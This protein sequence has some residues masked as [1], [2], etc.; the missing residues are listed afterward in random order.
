MK[1]TLRS[2]LGI[3]LF[4]SVLIT[5]C[6]TDQN[7]NETPST[8]KEIDKNHFV[9][10][11]KARIIA[12]KLNLQD[13]YHH[14][15]SPKDE[16]NHSI[17][18]ETVVEGEDLPTY[19]VFNYADVDGFAIISADLRC[20]PILAYSSG[21]A[22]PEIGTEIPAGLAIQLEEYIQH[23][24]ELRDAQTKL[25]D[26]IV[27]LWKDATPHVEISFDGLEIE[28]PTVEYINYKSE[29]TQTTSTWGPLVQ[30]Q[31]GQGCGYNNSAPLK[32]CS[33]C[34]SRALVGCVATATGQIMRYWQ[35]PSSYSWSSMPTGNNPNNTIAA[36][37][38]D[39]GDEVSMNYGC[40]ASSAKTNDARKALENEFG[41]STDADYKD[42]SQSTVKS[43][44]Q[45]NRPVILRGCRTREKK[46]ILFVSWYVYSNC[47]AWVC[48]GVKVITSSSST[49]TQLHM[50]WGWSGSGDAWFTS[51]NVNGRNYQYER[52]MLINIHP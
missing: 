33:N 4:F 47:H 41:Y 17:K 7:V 11:E 2:L 12:Q 8:V 3:T 6:T 27:Q 29:G 44:I 38:R 35:H 19:Y 16:F 22:F 37:L 40:D 30:T 50:N 42:Y 9:P 51:W 13:P 18:E 20:E 24:D 34:N 14:T 48:D 26:G 32:S 10:L 49:S 1:N 5:S 43:N 21:N 39:V 31:W 46:T 36:L 52:K 25:K 23:I 28:T 45:I 15:V